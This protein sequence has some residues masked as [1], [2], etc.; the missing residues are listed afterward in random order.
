[1]TRLKWTPF[2]L[3]EGSRAQHAELSGGATAVVSDESDGTWAAIVQT[4]IARIAPLVARPRFT[5][6][7]SAKAW[8]RAVQDVFLAGL[9]VRG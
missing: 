4:P 6:A 1:L 7:K 8:V 2:P 3:R 9:E 5:S